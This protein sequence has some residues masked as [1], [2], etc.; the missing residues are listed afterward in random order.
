MILSCRLLPL[1]CV[2]R[3]GD[4]GRDAVCMLVGY[5]ASVLVLSLHVTVDELHE[6][7]FLKLHPFVEDLLCI[8]NRECSQI[9]LDLGIRVGYLL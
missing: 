8:V 4:L 1:V 3:L 6:K 9:V 5:E 2:A 7:E